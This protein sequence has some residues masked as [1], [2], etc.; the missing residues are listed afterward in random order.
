LDAPLAL[1]ARGRRPVRPP[2]SARHWVSVYAL[3]PCVISTTL[4]NIALAVLVKMT[5]LM[6]ALFT[7]FLKMFRVYL[8]RVGLGLGFALGW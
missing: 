5:P 2:R 4:A 7:H 3:L 1:D 8:L 6:G